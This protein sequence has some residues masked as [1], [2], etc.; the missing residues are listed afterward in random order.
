[1]RHFHSI[2]LPQRTTTVSPR[3]RIRFF[4]GG[5]MTA[6]NCSIG[7]ALAL[8]ASFGTPEAAVR[9]ARAVV[10]EFQLSPCLPLDGV[11]CITSLK[12]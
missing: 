10:Q 5:S 9:S 2:N 6:G 7:F 8:L 1:M 11:R 4:I 3:P 12:P